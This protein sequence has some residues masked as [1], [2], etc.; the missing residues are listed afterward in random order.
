MCSRTWRACDSRCARALGVVGRLAGVEVRRERNLRVDDHDLLARETDDQVG[1]QPPV[2][3]RGRDL[4]VEVA[5]R[6]HARE[7]DDA[8]QLNLAPASPDVRRPQRGREGRGA[9]AQ[10]RQLAPE[11][12]VRPLARE[13][14][15]PHLAVDLLERLLQRPD[16]PRQLGFGDLEERRAVRLVR[17]RRRRADGVDDLV[18]ER[19]PLDVELR[20]RSGELALGNAQ[21]ARRDDPR[22]EGAE[23]ETEDEGEYDHGP[24]N[25]RDRRRT[26]RTPTGMGTIARR[27]PRKTRAP[28]P[29]QAAARPAA[30]L[31]VRPT[32]R[33]G[34]AAP[35]ALP[36]RRLGARGAR[37]RPRDRLPHG[38]RRQRRRARRARGRRLHA[39]ELPGPPEQVR[40]LG[41]ADAQDQ[42]E[43]E[44]RRRRRAGRTTAVP[45]VWDFYDEPVPLVQ[46]V[47]NLEHGGVV[48]H[49]G[50]QFP[51][52]RG[53]EDPRRGT[54][55]TTRTACSSRR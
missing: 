33:G 35:H 46:T 37:G 24:T 15:R 12:A 5:V 25:G 44:L 11:R 31:D 29:S 16:V 14:Q 21:T 4:L 18:V 53:R 50:P 22:D 9:L 49:Y 3:G 1:A 54:P 36:D 45:A 27:W 41:R 48:I 23:N 20:P 43:V 10:L 32:R 7:L 47:H 28:E 52:G 8:L 34:A 55:R 51:Q 26:A 6:Q 17:V 38:R 2:V 42:A 13:L 40:P 39:P 19:A 30:A